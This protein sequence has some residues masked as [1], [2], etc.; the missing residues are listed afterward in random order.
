MFGTNSALHVE[1]VTVLW[2]WAG[3]VIMVVR[4]TVTCVIEGSMDFMVWAT[5]REL[6]YNR[7]YG[8]HSVG[9]GV[10]EKVSDR[11]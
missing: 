2:Y 10:W 6:V 1:T 5:V 9:Y 7:K 11:G 8:P 3:I 4:S